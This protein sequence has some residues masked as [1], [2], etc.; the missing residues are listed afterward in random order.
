MT[1][2]WHLS[3]YTASR[4]TINPV[5]IH[6]HGW[7]SCNTPPK[8]EWKRLNMMSF[9]FTKSSLTLTQSI[10]TTDW[11]TDWLSFTHLLIK[12]LT[13]LA[14]SLIHSLIDSLT[15]Q[16]THSLSTHP[17]EVRMLCQFSFS[18]DTKIQNR[19]LRLGT[20][21]HTSILFGASYLSFNLWYAQW[22]TCSSNRKPRHLSQWNLIS[23][24]AK[25]KSQTGAR[26]L[27]K[28]WL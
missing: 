7:F 22:T 8:V 23:V 25:Y 5:A 14:D 3:S 24:V 20:W 15:H 27:K 28:I 16:L 26:G 6:R 2:L 21:G 12:S 13:S 19:A 9:S 17:E 1:E 4:E 11:L 10:S 18:K